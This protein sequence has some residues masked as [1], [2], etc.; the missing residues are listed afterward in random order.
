MKNNKTVLYKDI[1]WYEWKYQVSTLW[2]VI[3]LPDKWQVKL[4][5][6]KSYSSIEWEKPYISLCENWKKRNYPVNILV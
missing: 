5:I 6:L 4:K 3:R 2:E 1:T